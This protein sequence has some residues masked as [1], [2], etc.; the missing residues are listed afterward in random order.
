VGVNGVGQL[1]QAG[2]DVI[3]AGVEL[4]QIDGESGATLVEPPTMVRP[5]PPRAFSSW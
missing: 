1:A 5:I 2:H 4:P 3:V